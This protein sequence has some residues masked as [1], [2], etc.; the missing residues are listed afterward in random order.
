MALRIV[1]CGTPEFAVPSLRH[2]IAQAD[3]HVERVVAQPDR[4]R[5]R[6]QKTS[7]LPVKDAALGAGI[8]VYQPEK[9]RSE[10]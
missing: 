2:L 4:P 10:S 9:I 8:A 1:F 7:A 3:F 6:G 5:G